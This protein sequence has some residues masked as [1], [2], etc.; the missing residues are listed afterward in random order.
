[1]AQQHKTNENPTAAKQSLV[2]GF[3]NKPAWLDQ[4][5]QQH[6]TNE[7]P[8]AAKQSLVMGFSNKLDVVFT[9]YIQTGHWQGPQKW[10]F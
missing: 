5:A 9:T 1:M 4:I 2:V 8:T 3:S 10:I 7:N 6:K